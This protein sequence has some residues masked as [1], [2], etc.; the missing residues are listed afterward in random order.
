MKATGIVRKMDTLG[1][2]VI[3]VELRRSMGIDTKDSIEIYT[4]GV[5]IFLKK[6]ASGC[7]FCGEVTNYRYQGHSV[8][9]RCHDI[10]RN[11]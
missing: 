2:V 10:L 6:Y 11:Q 1:R 3:P 8:C 9:E 4:D 7:I 5:S